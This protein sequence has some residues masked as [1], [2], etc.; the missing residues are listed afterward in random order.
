MAQIGV[1]T[2]GAGVTTS[3]NALSQCPSMIMLGTV[4]TAN[5]LT[6]LVVEIGG[7]SFFNI[8]GQAAI[9]SAIAK[10]M[11]KWVST[12]QGVVF[13][14]ATGL[15]KKTTNIR[16]TNGGATVPIIYGFSDMPS[17]APVLAGTTTVNASSYEDFE[18]FSALF[19]GTPAN[20]GSAEISYAN[21]HKETVSGVELDAIFAMKHD[22]EAAGQLLGVTVIDN[23]DQAIS[24]IRLNIIT[25]AT[26]I[27][28]MK[29]PDEAF[30]QIQ[31]M[32]A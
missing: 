30:K 2:T 25:A 13:P 14:V 23:T 19:I 10:F 21:G 32:A 8:T 22:T 17:G 28:I 18:K 26:T 20:V 16:L 31:Q 27:A 6:G 7:I 5:P 1:L 29:L 4:A 24:S 9:L 11:T 12:L 3:L 15:I